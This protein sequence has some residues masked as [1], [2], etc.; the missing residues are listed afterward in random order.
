VKNPQ[1][2]KK[3]SNIVGYRRKR[4]QLAPKT[5]SAYKAL[6]KAARAAG[7]K[8]PIF[9]VVSGYRS[10]AYQA[11][12]FK[13]ALK[14]YGSVKEARKWVAPPGKSVHRSGQAVDFYLGHPNTK[15]NVGKLKQT[16]A[17]KWMV[18]NA[19]R[20]GFNP[21]TRE[22]WHWEYNLSRPGGK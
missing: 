1:P 8:N 19:G 16:G 20:F 2:P 21:Y 5:A 17:W 3:V 22:P 11:G 6:I 12:L 18:K 14:K 9:S 10:D 4:I 15:A 13:N 7:F